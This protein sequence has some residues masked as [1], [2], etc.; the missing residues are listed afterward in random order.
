MTKEEKLQSLRSSD[1]KGANV[2]IQRHIKK[3]EGMN[4][5]EFAS[6]LRKLEDLNGRF[7]RSGAASRMVKEVRS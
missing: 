3:I 4:E 1:P 6:H 7:T 2:A 5:L